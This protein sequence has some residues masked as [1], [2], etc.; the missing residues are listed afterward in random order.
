LH[1]LYFDSTPDIDELIEKVTWEGL[2]L[3]VT[4]I[5]GEPELIG[6]IDEATV[7][8]ILVERGLKV[9]AEGSV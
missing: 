4:F 3:P 7:I 8:E 6:Y 9:A 5:D 1:N 2:K